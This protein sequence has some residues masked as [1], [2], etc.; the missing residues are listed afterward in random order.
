MGPPRLPQPPLHREVGGVLGGW[1]VGQL[2]VCAILAVLYTIGFYISHV[3]GWWILGIVCAA[4]N[5]IP[6]LGGVIALV[7]AVGV[8]WIGTEDF[9][10][11]IGALITYVIVQGLEGFVLTPRIVGRRVQLSPVAVFLA[12]L[13]GGMLFGPL[14]IVLAV[15]VLAILG[16]IWRR[17]RRQ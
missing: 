12:V 10:A 9:Y 3:P 1:I 6:V 17:N 16:V 4:L 14:G 13:F 11:P 5:L 7:L 15:P 8:A 2:K